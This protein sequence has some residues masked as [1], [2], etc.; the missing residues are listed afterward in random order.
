M[1]EYFGTRMISLADLLSILCFLFQVI[2]STSD[3]AQLGAH[4]TPVPKVRGS[5]RVPGDRVWKPPKLVAAQLTKTGRAVL[6]T[7]YGDLHLRDP[8]GRFEKE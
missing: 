3:K 8:L 4:E 7:V 1:L 5:T 6:V 2:A